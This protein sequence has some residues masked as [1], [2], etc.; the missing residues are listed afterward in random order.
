MWFRCRCRVVP[1]SARKPQTYIWPTQ[2]RVHILYNI[3]L[4]PIRRVLRNPLPHGG[5]GGV[6]QVQSD[7]RFVRQLE[8]SKATRWMSPRGLK[9][10][11]DYT[12]I[13]RRERRWRCRVPVRPCATQPLSLTLD[14]PKATMKEPA[15]H[16]HLLHLLWKMFCCN[17]PRSCWCCR[18]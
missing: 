5:G 13:K 6:G 17:R 8:T 3:H 4:R 2:S 9:L 15:W 18:D 7:H 1:Y 10:Q 16:S 11:Q 12:Q 14:P